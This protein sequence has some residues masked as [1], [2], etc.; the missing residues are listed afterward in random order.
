[1][2][3][4]P[5]EDAVILERAGG[6]SILPTLYA[7]AVIVVGLYYGR[8]LMVPLVMAALLA[9]VLAPACGALQ[10]LK[11]PRVIAVLVVVI[12]AFATIG[13]L[14]VVVGRQAASLA[15]MPPAL[16]AARL[17]CLSILEQ[18]STVEAIRY[19]IK[20][21]QK[22][23]PETA[24][25]VALWHADRASPLPSALRAEGANEHLVLSIGELLALCHA[26]AARSAVT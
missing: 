16:R 6:R 1:M 10:R 14:G 26:L 21:V 11:L 19:V 15:G 25:V 7:G 13:G 17:C 3:Q 4:L 22:Q 9:F 5:S 12:F 24:I 2:K 8:E 20:R 23:M 18:G